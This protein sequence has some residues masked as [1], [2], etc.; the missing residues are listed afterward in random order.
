M[1]K[2]K[3][4]ISLSELYNINSGKC[5]RHNEIEYP[6]RKYDKFETQAL[7]IIQLLSTSIELTNQEIA[8]S[9]NGYFRAN[10]VASINT[11][12]KY[13]YLWDGDFPIRKVRVPKNYA[14]KQKIAKD[15]LEY[16]FLQ[17]EQGNQI[18]QIQ[19]QRELNKG[20]SIVEKT[21]RGIY[22]YKVE[23]YDYPIKL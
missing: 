21:L 5:L 6:I 10:E 18:T 23:G 1:L 12:K 9:V 13:A 14:E 15:I 2:E 8:D 3:Y 22:P 16:I 11:G 4:N 7:K 17:K 19:I 20:R